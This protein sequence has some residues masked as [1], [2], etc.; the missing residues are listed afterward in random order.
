MVHPLSWEWN[1]VVFTVAIFVSGFFGRKLY[2]GKEKDTDRPFLNRRLEGLVGKAFV[3]DQPIEN[4]SGRIR[5]EDSVWRVVGPD[6]P[7]GSRVRVT[8][9]HN[10]VVLK[11]E[12]V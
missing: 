7:A 5:V 2:G 11:V 8:G 12:R 3:L 6:T 9:T 10:G 1:L 4:G